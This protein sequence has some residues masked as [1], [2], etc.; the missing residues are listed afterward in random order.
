MVSIFNRP[1]SNSILTNLSGGPYW[2]NPLHGECKLKRV[3]GV[4]HDLEATPLAA[5]NSSTNPD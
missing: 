3:G 2:A 1:S 4:V 5:L